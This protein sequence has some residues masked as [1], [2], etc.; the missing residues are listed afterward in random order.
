MA[1]FCKQCS[2]ELFGEDFEELA[3]LTSAE[4]WNDGKARVVL[5]E[6]CGPIQVDPDGNCVSG[7]CYKKGH[8]HED[9]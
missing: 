2:T 1:A 7:D 6:D 4:D 5:C 9:R 8:N 3:G